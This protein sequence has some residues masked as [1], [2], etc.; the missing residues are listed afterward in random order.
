MD[1]TRTFTL[2]DAIAD[3][4]IDLID[5]V[6]DATTRDRLVLVANSLRNLAAAS[7]APPAPFRE[8]S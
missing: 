7:H 3:D 6:D 1:Q 5:A 2:I 8:A 4:V